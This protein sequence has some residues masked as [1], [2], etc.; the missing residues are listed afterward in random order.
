VL[1]LDLGTGIKYTD[2][3]YNDSNMNSESPFK[4]FNQNSL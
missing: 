2:S 4:V 1:D 3:N